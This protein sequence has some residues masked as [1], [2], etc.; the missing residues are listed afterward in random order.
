MDSG[1]GPATTELIRHVFDAACLALGD[2]MTEANKARLEGVVIA[3]ISESV[4]GGELD[5]ERL[6]ACALESAREAMN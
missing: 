4:K 1:F 5:A 3:A 2:R 6:F